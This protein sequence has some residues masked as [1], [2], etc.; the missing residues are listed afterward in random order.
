MQNNLFLECVGILTPKLIMKKND[1]VKI[2]ISGVSHEG[3]GIGKLD[4]MAVFVRGA[5]IGDVVEAIIIKMA[6]N[7]AVGKLSRV[8]SASKDRI[9][10]DCP[11]FPRCG[12]CVYRHISYSSEAALKR[13]RVADCLKR[14]GGIDFCPD[15][16][17]CGQDW[18]YRNKAQYPV[19]G[20]ASQLL[21]GFYANHSHRIISCTDCKLQPPVFEKVVNCV[22]EFLCEHSITPYDEKS[23]KGLVRHIY[24]RQG[25]VTK[26]MMVCLV[27][28]GKHLPHCDELVKALQVIVGD[29]LKT[30]VLNINTAD[31]NVVMSTNC[32]PLYGDGCITDLLCGIKVRLNALSF[33]QVNHTMAERLYAKAAEFAGE[34]GTLIDLYCGAGTIGL[35]MANR[36]DR[37]VGVEV[38][39]EAVEDA[40]FN[41]AENGIENAQFIC[42][43]A[44]EAAKQLHDED[45]KPDVVIVD[46]PRKGLEEGL[47]RHIAENMAPKRVVYV[48]CDPATMARDLK[49]F[50]ECGYKLTKAVPFD[51]FPRTAH[52]ETV[53]LLNKQSLCDKKQAFF[54]NAKLLADNF[55]IIPLLYGS[56]GLEHLTGENLNADDV[57]ILIPKAFITEEWDEFKSVL[58]NN[59]YTLINEH[60]HEFEKEGVHYSY[61][62]IEELERFADISLSEIAVFDKDGVAYKLL[63]LTQYLKVYTASSKDGYRTSVREKKDFDKIAFIQKK[64]QELN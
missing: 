7:Y 40:K 59:G 41:A 15:E 9:E 6:K 8:I 31:T 1:I 55:Q 51:L 32:K 25:A 2:E 33:Y 19:G 18:G 30:V 39:P 22:S 16:T 21:V 54:E 46:P 42:G 29:E 5:A 45:I 14:I 13:Q 64:L 57:D 20:N 53:A 3:V 37:V 49:A 34:G 35:S 62:Q 23:G 63:S 36:F 38:I 27:I 26:E 10:N 56:L 44:Y 58:E 52:I 61:A 47:P 12:G 43:D 50:E 4:G 24:I 11:A 60:E 28:N 48:S 17:Q